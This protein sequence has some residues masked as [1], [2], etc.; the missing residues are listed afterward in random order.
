MKLSLMKALSSSRGASLWSSTQNTKAAVQ[1][2]TS[3]LAK[4]HRLF[5]FKILR[6]TFTPTAGAQSLGR[7]VLLSLRIL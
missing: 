4:A 6:S 1:R 5:G 2:V 3:R 7:S